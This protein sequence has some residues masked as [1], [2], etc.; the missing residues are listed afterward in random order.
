MKHKKIII[1]SAAAAFICVAALLAEL[2]T[3][4]I[5]WCVTPRGMVKNSLL[6]EIPEQEHIGSVPDGEIRYLINNNVVFNFSG[7][8]GN[9]MFENPESCEYNLVFT[10]YEIVGDGEEENVI[11][12]SP[13]IKPGQSLSGDK[14]K[15]RIPAG[16]YACM[17]SVQAYSGETYAGERTGPMTVT[18]MKQS[19]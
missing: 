1:I 19:V 14:L 17:Y 4:G 8:K 13:V 10:V 9:L 11:Y 16:E 2:L 18:V 15:K 5:L 6:E 3:P 12:T 7:G